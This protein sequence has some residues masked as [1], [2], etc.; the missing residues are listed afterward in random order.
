MTPKPDT[1]TIFTHQCI[2]TIDIMQITSKSNC[3]VFCLFVWVEALRPSQQFFKHVRTFSW[4]EPILSNT[5]VVSCSRTQ[6][7]CHRLNC[8]YSLGGV[9]GSVLM[10][11]F[12]VD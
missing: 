7:R 11:I 10:C 4:V 1:I 3:N 9:M 12:N 6:H 5:E 2:Y 8:D